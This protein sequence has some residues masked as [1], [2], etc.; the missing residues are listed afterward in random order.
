MPDNKLTFAEIVFFIL[1]LPA[2]AWVF[3]WINSLAPTR[4]AEFRRALRALA[5]GDFNNKTPN[6]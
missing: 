4:A 6:G 3:F 5:A 1:A 2:F